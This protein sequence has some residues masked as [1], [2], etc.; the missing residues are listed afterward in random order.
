[1]RIQFHFHAEMTDVAFRF[2]KCTAHVMVSYQAERER[3][4]R[5]FG[6][7][8]SSGNSRIG[9][10]HNKIGIDRIF[11]RQNFPHQR[12]ARLDRSAEYDAVR[13]REIDVLENAL[14]EPWR[15]ER[16]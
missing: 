15:V 13:P 14:R 10:R 8:D 6:I 3:D 7:T 1:H 9:N 2:D 11:L 16:L 5:L 4:A 12:A